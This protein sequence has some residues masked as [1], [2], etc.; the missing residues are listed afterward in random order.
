MKKKKH[1]TFD[2]S[3]ASELLYQQK[4]RADERAFQT[5]LNSYSGFFG[6]SFYPYDCPIYP[7]INSNKEDLKNQKN[8]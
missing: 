4:L 3:E 7:Q 8:K 5:I 2:N 1:H 6:V